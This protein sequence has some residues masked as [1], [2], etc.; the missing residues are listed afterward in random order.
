MTPFLRQMFRVLNKYWMVP[1]FRLG[2]GCWVVNP[3]TGY[4]AV[5]KT[6]GRR[7]GRVRPA[8]VN[9]MIHG[10]AVYFVSGGREQ[11]DWYRN[12]LA[13][14]EIDVLLPSGAVR[15]EAEVVTDPD[16][17]LFA[18]RKVLRSAGFAG[19]FEGYNPH[20]IDDAALREKIA[21]LP[22]L[23]LRVPG[24]AGGADDPGGWGWAVRN[25]AGFGLY[26]A[27]RRRR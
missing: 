12:L 22:V 27:L 9:Y 14:P 3:F 21:D 24:L 1:L 5:L 4:I 19:F 2:L 18:A 6:I 23:R 25:V 8:P 16:E 7:S 20:T 11:S 26:L 10:G 15:G 13:H 17:R